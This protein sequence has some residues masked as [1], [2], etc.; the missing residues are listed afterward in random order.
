MNLATLLASIADAQIAKDDAKKEELKSEFLKRIQGHDEQ[1]ILMESLGS[2]LAGRKYISFG[3]NACPPESLNNEGF[4]LR[5][6]GC[7]FDY[8]FG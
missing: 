8:Y 3:R 2:A 5:D 4:K 1:E 7:M 6:T